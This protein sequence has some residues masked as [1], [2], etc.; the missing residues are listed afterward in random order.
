MHFCVSAVR[1][2]S[3][4]GL[5]FPRKIGTNWFMPA[6]VNSRFGASGKSGDDGTMV[7]PFDL[8]KSRKLWRISDEVIVDYRSAGVSSAIVKIIRARERLQPGRSRYS[9]AAPIRLPTEAPAAIFWRTAVMIASSDL[10][11]SRRK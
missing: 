9:A 10:G 8:K 2:G 7:C 11:F 1:G 5:T 4:C 6:L 3:H